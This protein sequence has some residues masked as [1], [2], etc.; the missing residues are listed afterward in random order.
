MENMDKIVQRYRDGEGEQPGVF[1]RHDISP[2]KKLTPEWMRQY[3]EA[4]FVA[5]IDGKTKVGYQDV[6]LIQ[7]NRR[8]MRGEQDSSIYR[9]Q[10][11]NDIDTESDID[12][13]RKGLM[14]IDWTPPP[15]AP[16]YVNI[17]QNMFHENN[18]E[19]LINALDEKS[20]KEKGAK[21]WKSWVT[22]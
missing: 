20:T 12:F 15:I 21:K 7:E 18:F 3:S 19:I 6:E 13:I 2:K 5:W 4:I 16:K 14:N 1:P 8:F 11:L 10:F 22:N 17:I 9:K